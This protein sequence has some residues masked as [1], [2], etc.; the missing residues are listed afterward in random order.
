MSNMGVPELLVLALVVLVI[1]AV[2]IAV[3]L[4]V[5]AA[6]RRGASGAVVMPAGPMTPPELTGHLRDLVA[7]NKRIHA[8]K[9]LRERTGMGLKDAK[10]AV[11]ALAAGYPVRHPALMT[12]PAPPAAPAAQPQADLA[13]RVRHLKESGQTERAVFLVR[14]ETGMNHDEATLFVNS[15]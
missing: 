6:N 5:T 15:L 9:L 2:I 1:A 11:E 13:T 3:V 7:Q 8:I 14:G 12:P 10:N 4:A